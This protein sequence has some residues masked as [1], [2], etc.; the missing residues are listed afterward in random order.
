[1][2]IKRFETVRGSRLRFVRRSLR[3]MENM[4]R[5][6]AVAMLSGLVAL[7]A[8]PSAALA[9]DRPLDLTMGGRPISRTGPVAFFHGGVAYVSANE[10]V[11]AYGGLTS[12]T[13]GATSITL[14]PRTAIFTPGSSVVRVDRA[15]LT[16]PAPALVSS[17]SLYVPLEF[18]VSNV[19]RGTVR[20]NAGSGTADITVV[21][22]PTSG[23]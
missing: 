1:M 21:T 14:G 8:L 12:Q 13:G 3:D 22:S 16:M 4:L 18:F 23:P 5:R 2:Y 7:S 20:I 17:G 10:L 6:A 9:A 19:A 15:P 11:R